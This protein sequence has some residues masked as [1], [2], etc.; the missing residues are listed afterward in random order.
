MNELDICVI[1]LLEGS[2]KILNE[3]KISSSTSRRESLGT[4]RK[5]P[6][7]RGSRP[8]KPYLIGLTGGIAS[9]KTHISQFLQSQGCDVSLVKL[10][11]ISR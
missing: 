8:K 6:N 11:V 10:V 1:K 5:P 9:G 7:D 4:L 3:I 2:D